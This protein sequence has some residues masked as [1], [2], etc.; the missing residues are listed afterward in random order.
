[1]VSIVN[2]EHTP[3]SKGDLGPFLALSCAS[4]R[5][6]GQFEPVAPFFWVS[7][8]SLLN[9]RCLALAFVENSCID[10]DRLVYQNYL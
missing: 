9:P 5:Q 4:S 7:D 3:R 8:S 10:E 1:M 6:V 2:I